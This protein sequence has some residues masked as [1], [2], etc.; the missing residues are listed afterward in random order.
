MNFFFVYDQDRHTLTGERTGV[1]YR[2][3]DRLMVRLR[4]VDIVTGGVIVSIEDGDGKSAYKPRRGHNRRGGKGRPGDKPARGKIK[5]VKKKKR[6]TPK[7][8][9]RA[10]A[11]KDK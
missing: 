4:E 11:K 8:K 1:T 6:T 10:A 2:L 9:K 3:A 5:H 7:G